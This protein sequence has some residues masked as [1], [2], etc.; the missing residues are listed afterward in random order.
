MNKQTGRVISNSAK[1]DIKWGLEAA[2][3]RAEGGKCELYLEW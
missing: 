3:E 1:Q 2:V